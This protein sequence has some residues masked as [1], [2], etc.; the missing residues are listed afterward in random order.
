MANINAGA[1]ITAGGT[2][3]RF[4]GEGI[5]ELPKQFIPLTG[6]PVIIHSIQSFEISEFISEIVVVVP[7]NL[8]EY[9]QTEIVDKFDIKKVL[10]VIGGGKQRQ[11]SVGIGL[12]S[13]STT[14]EIVVVHDGVRPFITPKIIGDVINQAADTGAAIAAIP[15]TDTI[16]QSG[17]EQSI[18]RTLSREKIWLAQTPQAF[19]H[20]ILEEAFE[21]AAKEG[22][23]GTDEAELV[24]RLGK[25]IKL[26]LASKYNIKITT[27][28]DLELGELILAGNLHNI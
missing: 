23:L 19:Q 12:G 16:K 11:E 25:K 2:G 5:D 15:A 18:E 7:E 24:E 14:T 20:Q 17:S 1:I 13:L 9:T 3:K 8:I 10:K 6:K 4:H 27:A 21:K 28:E 26:V 22:Y